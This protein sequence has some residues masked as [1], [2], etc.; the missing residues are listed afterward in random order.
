M[1]HAEIIHLFGAL[2]RE[3][4]TIVLVTHDLATGRRE[5]T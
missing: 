1:R 2:N 4:T 5:P 3:G